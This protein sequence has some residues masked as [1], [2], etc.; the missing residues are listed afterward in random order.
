MAKLQEVQQVGETG[1]FYTPKQLFSKLKTL[2]GLA[3]TVFYV[4]FVCDLVRNQV[5][6]RHPTDVF[7]H[8]MSQMMGNHPL[9]ITELPEKVFEVQP[10]I[11]LPEDRKMAEHTILAV[12]KQIWEV[13][14]RRMPTVTAVDEQSHRFCIFKMYEE[15]ISCPL[16]VHA[17]KKIKV[18]FCN[19]YGNKET[20]TF[21]QGVNADG[22]VVMKLRYT[23][24]IREFVELGDKLLGR[25]QTTNSTEKAYESFAAEME[26]K[27]ATKQLSDLQNNDKLHEALAAKPL[28]ESQLTAKQR[29]DCYE[30][31]RMYRQL[32]GDNTDG[33]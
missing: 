27:A 3:D 8:A 32:Y 31:I 16:G 10:P 17:D 5:C 4:P 22:T 18:W 15:E 12:P 19:M 2:D 11:I 21:F 23:P 28:E 14:I 24:P 33:Q 25:L 20:Y 26:Q 29:A 9:V 7:S 6:T 1:T 30:M 13:N